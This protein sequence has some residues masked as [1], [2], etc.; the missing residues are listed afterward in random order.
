MRPEEPLTRSPRGSA[1]EISRVS[2]AALRDGTAGVSAT[3]TGDTGTGDTGT[4]DTGTREEGFA[5]FASQVLLFI[6]FYACLLFTALSTLRSLDLEA[7]IWPVNALAA[8]TFLLLLGTGLGWC[9]T[10]VAA[11]GLM[12]HLLVGD[13]LGPALA[14]ALAGTLTFSLTILGCRWAR[15]RPGNALEVRHVVGL[16]LLALAAGLPGA[17]VKAMVATGG[18]EHFWR[19]AGELWLPDASAIVLLLPLFLLWGMRGEEPPVAPLRVG[20]EPSAVRVP[21]AAVASL[22]LAGSVVLAVMTREMQVLDLGGWILLWFAFRLGLFPTALA[23]ALFAVAVLVLAISN[24]WHLAPSALPITLLKLQGQL[25]MAACPALIIAAIM[26]QRQRQQRALEEDQRRLSYALEG[27]NDGIWDWHVPSDTI[28]FS[29]RAY[30]MLG[31]DPA[32]DK[33]LFSRFRSLV[34]PDDLPRMIEA[35]RDHTENRRRLFQVELRGRHRNG[36]YVWLHLRGKIVERDAAGGAVRAVGTITDVSQRKHLEAALE[37]AASHDPLTGLANRATF[38]RAL[39]Q[40]RRRLARDNAPFAVLLIDVDHFKAVNDKHGH[41]AGDLVLTTTARRLQSA[42]RA[43]DTAA[44]F[45]GDE[46]AVIAMGKTPAEFAALADRLHAQIS[47]SVETEGLVL[48]A[49]F[50]IGMAVATS[51]ATDPIALVAEADAALYL[52]KHEGRGTW[53]ALGMMGQNASLVASE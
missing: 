30:R 19:V 1:P 23:S 38:D 43:G 17:L 45:G 7:L 44:R 14:G 29:T 25:V 52:A 41:V 4:G 13:A 26:A 2:A 9:A 11:A 32:T 27:A 39:E 16:V 48:P 5:Q 37:H 51:P 50:S 18:G 34:H 15:L 49:S 22:A 35:F 3:G 42:L 31:Y 21:E 12:V 28:F 53:R 47:R 33:T 10:G 36:A 40:A 6:V 24:V 46:F 20:P 8:G